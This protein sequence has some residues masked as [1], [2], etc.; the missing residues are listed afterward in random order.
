MKFI[1]NVKSKI[2]F[3]VELAKNF[4]GSFKFKKIYSC[5]VS[6]QPKKKCLK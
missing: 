5:V 6:C 2:G 3:L 1:Q 4:K